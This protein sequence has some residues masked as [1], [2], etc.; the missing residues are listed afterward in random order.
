MAGEEER[1]EEIIEA[2]HVSLISSDESEDEENGLI[3]RPLCF[4]LF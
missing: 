3:T 1:G 2:L 4:K